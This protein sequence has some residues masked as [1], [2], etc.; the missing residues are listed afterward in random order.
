[1]KSL[2]LFSSYYESGEIPYYIRI[3]LQELVRHNQRVVFIS[4]QQ[5]LPSDSVAF[6]KRF[7]IHYLPVQDEGYD[8]GMWSKGLARYPAEEYDRL[9]LVNDSCVLVRKLDEVLAT[10]ELNKWDY[11]G[12]MSSSEVGFHLQSYFLVFSVKAIASL[13]I[14]LNTHGIQKSMI[15]V[16]HTYEVGLAIYMQQQGLDTG[17]VFNVEHMRSGFNPIYTFILSLLDAGFP[18]IKKKQLFNTFNRKERLTLLRN[19]VEAGTDRYLNILETSFS[20]FIDIKKLKED[21]LRYVNKPT[22][23]ML[24]N[25][26]GMYGVIRR[27]LGKSTPQQLTEKAD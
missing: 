12:L 25:Y 22:L 9:M 15:D 24:N 2:C 18:L 26:I 20:G 21:R 3:Y 17:T 5:S 27:L 19:G 11:A 14:Y 16:I 13:K 7:E 6:L 4:N 8:F 1:M 10:I 23:F